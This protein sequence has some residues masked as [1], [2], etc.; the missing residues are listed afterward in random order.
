[1]G[2]A[3]AA[4]RKKNVMLGLGSLLLGALT[5]LVQAMPSPAVAPLSGPYVALGDSYAAGPVIPNQVDATCLRSDHNYPSLVA[6]ALHVS[7]FRDVSC[8]GAATVDMTQSQHPTALTSVPPQ[9]DAVRPDTRLVTLTIGG[10]DIGFS[11]VVITCAQL[12]L[13]DPSGDPCEKYYTAGGTD[14]LAAA[15][16]ATA[17]KVA[18]VL[19][20]IHQRAPNAR[21][22][23]VGYLDILPVVGPGCWPVVP[24]AAGDVAYLRGIETQ[25]NQM[26]SAQAALSGATFVD[27][28][29]P[30]I[31]H[32]A[33]QPVGV[34]WVEAALPMSPAYPVHPNALGMQ[35][36][37]AAV[38]N[39]RG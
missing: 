7:T 4:M 34:K 19:Q 5:V 36:D 28:Y 30:S 2:N 21:V 22:A 15:V 18:A 31:G 39:A 24:F 16:A 9:L 25:L 27:T 20:A 32:D 38:L 26:L 10:N 35:A 11:N 6:A 23:L 29:T 8:T 1:M 12:S 17:P 14:T 37:A 33:C 3:T 13:L